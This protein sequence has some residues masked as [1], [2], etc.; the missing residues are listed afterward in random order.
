MGSEKG[1]E[2]MQP[3]LE[4]GSKESEQV[5]EVGVLDQA[6]SKQ[7]CSLPQSRL[8]PSIFPTALLCVPPQ[9]GLGDSA[10]LTNARISHVISGGEG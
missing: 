1:H 10:T 7:A 2:V 5:P 3:H 4:V 9:L 8:P 6:D